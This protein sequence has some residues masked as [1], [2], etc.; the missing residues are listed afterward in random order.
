MTPLEHF[1]KPWTYLAIGVFLAGVF[2]R[3]NA[4]DAPLASDELA[5]ASIW[6]QMPYEKIPVNYQYPN[7]HIFHTIL[8]SFI[9][10]T[11]GPH[12]A[13]IRIP[14]LIAGIGSLVLTY[15]TT[16]KVSQNGPAALGALTLMAFSVSPVFYS[17]NARG[18]SLLMLFALITVWLLYPVLIPQKNLE[19]NY[20]KKTSWT[21]CV[22]LVVI[23]SIGTWTVPTFVYFEGALIVW[24]GTSLIFSQQINRANSLR[25]L[26]CIAVAIVLF[27]I[28]YFVIIGPDMLKVAM[29]HAAIIPTKY[30]FSQL[31]NEWTQPWTSCVSLFLAFSFLG[32]CVISCHNLNA[33]IAFAT[34]MILPPLIGVLA[35]NL[36]LSQHLPEPRV[37]HYSIPF[38]FVAV[39]VGA[40]WTCEW[41]SGYLTKGNDT[42]KRLLQI[43]LAT[44]ILCLIAF[45]GIRDFALRVT[46]I[47][48]EREPYH[49]IRDFI[50]S[51]GPRD[52]ILT[53]NKH[54]IWFY[55]YGANAMRE[56]VSAILS[57]GKIDGI[58][59]IANLKGKDADTKRVQIKNQRYLKFNDFPPVALSSKT[60]SSFM[61]SEG[62]L[63]L[64]KEIGSFLFFKVKPEAM[65][66]TAQLG[67]AGDRRHWFVPEEFSNKVQLHPTDSTLHFQSSFYMLTKQNES[68][69]FPESEISF[70]LARAR[71]PDSGW[72]VFSNGQVKNKSVSFDFTWRGN[73][74]VLDHPYGPGIFKRRWRSWI[75]ISRQGFGKPTLAVKSGT[76]RKTGIVQ[77]LTAYSI[78]L[79]NDQFAVTGKTS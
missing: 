57:A 12:P 54:H 55:L 33:G 40:L 9:L 68:K 60:S 49:K 51:L 73:D 35:A 61:V 15:S 38:F 22:S 28:Q 77:S 69:K 10:K 32:L 75:F 25:L 16:L 45:W 37:F 76:E 11:L 43:F 44:I 21:L 13:A 31:L 59:F 46:P 63:R 8:V 78:N 67:V 17:T 18:Y 62:L 30:F 6:A 64:E 41:T 47:L 65:H 70:F 24:V 34:F 66:Q 23:W 1:T 58:Y 36:G 4:I 42:I 50:K 19:S 74:L 52:L 27:Y 3:L 71:I 79:S 29:S 72:L 56:R 26:I 5:T 39:S 14:A 20:F 2:L 53:S 7:N 48:Q